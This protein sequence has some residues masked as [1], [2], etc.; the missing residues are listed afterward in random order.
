MKNRKEKDYMKRIYL[1]GISG[2]EEQYRI[3]RYSYIDEDSIS[4]KNIMYFSGWLQIKNP[5][6]EHVYAIDNRKGLFGDY[7]EALEQNSI[8]SFAIF[9]DILEREGIQ[10]I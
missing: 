7:K 3:V 1:Y 8:E 5:S 10:V 6:I 4:I 9:K 2:A